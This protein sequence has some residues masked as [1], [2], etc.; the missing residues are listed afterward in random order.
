MIGTEKLILTRKWAL[1]FFTRKFFG[2]EISRSGIT[3][4]NVN[5]V[6]KKGKDKFFFDL[7]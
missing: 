4:V 2:H 5:K 6:L 3:H 1:F 7:K